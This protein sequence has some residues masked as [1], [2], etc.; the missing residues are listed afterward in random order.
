MYHMRVSINYIKIIAF[1]IELIN[2]L[3]FI[4]FYLCFFTLLKI[5]IFRAY[6]NLVSKIRLYYLV[7]IDIYIESIVVNISL[8]QI[9]DFY[10]NIC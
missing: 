4:S 7:F 5:L 1:H 8:L 9:S 3:T 6:I 10:L 2:A